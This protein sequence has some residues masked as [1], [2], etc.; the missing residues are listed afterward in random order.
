[1]TDHP[2]IFTPAQIEA[3][4]KEHRKQTHSWRVLSFE[5]ERPQDSNV[6][7]AYYRAQGVELAAEALGIPLHEKPIHEQAAACRKAKK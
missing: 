1:M 4:N 2:V 3:I 6:E 7:C 5:G